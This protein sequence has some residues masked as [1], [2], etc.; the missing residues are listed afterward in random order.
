VRAFAELAGRIPRSPELM[1]RSLERAWAKHGAAM[2]AGTRDHLTV[3]AQADA[4]A[5]GAL[6]AAEA[7]YRKDPTDPNLAAIRGLTKAADK[8]NR[9]LFLKIE[10]L[11]PQSLAQMVGRLIQLNLMPP[12]SQVAN[13]FGNVLPAFSD[14][15]EQATASML[16]AVYT[17]FK[18]AALRAVHGSKAPQVRREQVNPFGDVA[19]YLRGVGTGLARVP[20]IMRTGIVPGQSL[21]AEVHRSFHPWR[22]FMQLIGK[23]DMLRYAS[24]FDNGVERLKKVL[25]MGS[26][27]PAALN[28]RMLGSMDQVAQTGAYQGAL[29]Q[30]ARV[31]LKNREITAAEARGLLNA[32]D[33]ATAAR[34]ADHAERMTLKNRNV[35][36]DV[37][38][39]GLKALN[40]RGMLGQWVDAL[41]VKPTIP[42]TQT[43]SNLALWFWN[44]LPPVAMFEAGQAMFAGKRRAAELGIARAITGGT[45]MLAAKWLYDAGVVSGFAESDEKARQMQYA[46]AENGLKPGEI[47]LSALVRVASTGDKT[48]GPVRKGDNIISYTRVQPYGALI[49][50]FAHLGWR[51]IQ[52]ARKEG[53]PIEEMSKSD[54]L[55]LDPTQWA[56]TGPAALQ[57]TLQQTM[58]KGTLSFLQA[59]MEGKWKEWDRNYIRALTSA[60]LPAT[61]EATMTAGEE[62]LPELRRKGDLGEEL[63]N[64]VRRRAGQTEGFDPKLEILGRPIPKTPPERNPYTFHLLDI[65]KWRKADVDP[66]FAMAREVWQATL[67]PR[68]YPA[69]PP[70]WITGPAGRRYDLDDAQ[71]NRYQTL[72]GE[73]RRTLMDRR[74]G[75]LSRQRAEQQI[76]SLTQI[77]AHGLRRGK[78]KM[79]RELKAGGE[80]GRPPTARE[81]VL[82]RIEMQRE[83]GFIPEPALA[84]E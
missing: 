48:Q 36:S 51:E 79:L 54:A 50:M 38:Q 22:A 83:S 70:A 41:L 77:Y 33:E 10:T 25:E 13:A 4:D 30:E 8:T 78:I 27:T 52:E 60:G 26:G 12:I 55:L 62:Y 5:R 46:G 49:A 43:P 58:L 20:G 21:M 73:E 81:R 65:S 23:E 76:Q 67:D 31:K 44:R 75:A 2:D 6:R 47:N 11:A 34:A 16:D 17:T 80:A 3:L 1:I 15:G 68:A 64:I 18:R 82:Q 14:F 45:M 19:S 71:W 37:A 29:S 35:I 9:D 39:A 28:A 7:V 69:I 63:K 72:V 56:K 61:I 40:D 59:T 66:Y 84:I 57:A 53:R 24:K 74:M 42:Y 32:P